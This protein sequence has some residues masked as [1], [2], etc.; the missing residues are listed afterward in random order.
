MSNS[1]ITV[2]KIISKEKKVQFTEMI[3]NLTEDQDCLDKFLLKIY[4]G[5]FPKKMRASLNLKF[6]LGF[7]NITRGTPR[8]LLTGAAQRFDLGIKE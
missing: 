4:L 2:Q 1:K 7:L 8:F 6:N 5:F 3:A